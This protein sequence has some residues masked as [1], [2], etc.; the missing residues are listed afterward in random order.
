MTVQ[1]KATGE[2]VQCTERYHAIR[3]QH[4]ASHYNVMNICRSSATNPQELHCC[5]AICVV[6]ALLVAPCSC[7]YMHVQQ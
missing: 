1:D 7:C 4:S 2:H 5:R 3:V 6:S